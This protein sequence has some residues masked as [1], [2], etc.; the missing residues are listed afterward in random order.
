MQANRTAGGF[1]LGISA[2]AAAFA[3][4]IPTP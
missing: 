3:R 4:P 1:D 2:S